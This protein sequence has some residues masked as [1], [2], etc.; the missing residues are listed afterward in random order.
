MPLT[1]IRVRGKRKRKIPANE[2]LGQKA[3]DDTGSPPKQ[4]QKRAVKKSLLERQLPLEV[5]ESIHLYSENLNFARS[6]PLLGL[7]FSGHQTLV[8]TIIA[9]FG[10][11]WNV[12]FGFCGG[13]GTIREEVFSRRIGQKGHEQDL[14]TLPRE[15]SDTLPIPLIPGNPQFQVCVLPPSL[16]FSLTHR[17]RHRSRPS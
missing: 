2:P 13:L 17:V 15:E 4:R 16:S 9:A 1:P 3:K 14:P 10:P 11:T 7:L 12:T 6:S 8:E 5:M